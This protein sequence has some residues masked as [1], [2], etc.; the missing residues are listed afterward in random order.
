MALAVALA[1]GIAAAPVIDLPSG[2]GWVLALVLVVAGRWARPRARWICLPAICAAGIA[3]GTASP[4]KIP[5]GATV[6]DR[7]VDRIEGVVD[8]RVVRTRRGFGALLAT[9][10]DA[11]W[12]WTEQRVLP[13][14]RIAVV[15]RLST[16]RGAVGPGQPDRADMLAARGAR[17]E[18]VTTGIE[19]IADEPGAVDRMWRWA[20]SVQETWS[21][22][23]DAVGG[24]AEARAALRGIVVGDRA[25]IPE[26][27]DARWRAVGV[28]HVLS[29]SGLH[30]AVIAGLA[31][32]ALRRLA[33]LLGGG[34][35]T[36]RWAAPPALALAIAYTLVTGAQIATL[37]ALIVIALVL[38]AAMLDRPLKLLDAIGVAAICVLV[39][40]PADLLDPSFQLSFVAAIVLACV[41]RSNASASANASA[42]II[43]GWLVRALVTSAW[44][45][46]ATAPLT[47]Y[48]FQQVT[49]GGIAGNVLLTPLLE[50]ACLPLA[51]AGVILDWEVPIR[52]AVWLVER[53]DGVAGWLEHAMPIGRIAIASGL[54][55][56]A[57]LVASLWLAARSRRTRADAIGWA[58][59][60][61]AWSLAVIPA[62]SGELRVSF[63]DVGQGDAAIIEL[64]DGAV[65]LVDAGGHANARD[66]AAATSPGKTIARTLAVYGKRRVDL[67]I[68]SHPHPDHYLG[69]ASLDVPI[70]ELWSARELEPAGE[71]GFEAATRS[72][73]HRTH[74]PLGLARSQAGVDLIVWAPRYHATDDAPA[75]EAADPVR[76][77]NDNSLVVEVR[78]RGRSIL[79]AGDLEGEGEEALVAAGVPDVDVVKVAHHGSPTSSTAAFVE[80]TRPELAVISC[81]R[82]NQFKFPSPAVVERWR[83]VGADIA[84]TDRD[85][86]VTVR[87]DA[88][89]R[90]TVQRF[91]TPVP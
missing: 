73:T 67:A 71:R 10:G 90:L 9:R 1:T 21:A 8:G 79:F 45:S 38:V 31:F 35:R 28:Y 15:G 69:F 12:I 36:A 87:V 34:V 50:L 17:L 23:I 81:G 85:G 49:P 82:A 63:V 55:V 74:P 37:R 26:S 53:V 52:V 89:G 33:S 4:T 78:Y 84:R 76:S 16:P 47:A 72:I 27:L 68:V 42:S 41:P 58:S 3:L 7:I 70:A 20:A 32:A 19:R 65:W 40:R 43:R 5:P 25:D 75:V 2:A 44:V 80:A 51:L 48:H 54:T 83:A 86:T 29:V 22:R 66:R 13:G 18:L 14:E 62:A 91:T 60:C 61:V 88:S 56:L 57:I 39:W 6:D 11:V 64:P 30:L 46:L 24:D 59:L 77:V